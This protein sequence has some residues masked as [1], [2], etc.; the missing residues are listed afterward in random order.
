MPVIF[1]SAS[2][3]YGYFV[4]RKSCEPLNKVKNVIAALGQL[5]SFLCALYVWR[6]PFGALVIRLHATP[7]FPPARHCASRA[8]PGFN[9]IPLQ[10]VDLLRNV[11][12]VN[13]CEVL[14][15]QSDTA[16]LF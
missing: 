3:A 16:I 15:L 13:G 12:W 1:Q 14:G 5:H 8:I 4:A 2:L 10:C 11:C 9:A 6:F 7:N